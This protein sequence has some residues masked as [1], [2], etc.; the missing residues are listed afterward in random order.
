MNKQAVPT[1]NDQ[2]TNA[3]IHEGQ[4]LCQKDVTPF[5]CHEIFQLAFGGFHVAMNL[6]WGI[7]KELSIKLGA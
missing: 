1:F 2:L 6:I 4:I 3:R 5:D 7:I